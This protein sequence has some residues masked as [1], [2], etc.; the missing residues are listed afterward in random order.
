MSS[1]IRRSAAPSGL[2]WPFI[3]GSQA[4]VGNIQRA[5][6]WLSF[7]PLDVGLENGSPVSLAYQPPFKFT[8]NL[9]KVDFVVK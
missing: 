7:E 9:E 8:G 3:N 1:R 2:R 5:G 4:G 6:A